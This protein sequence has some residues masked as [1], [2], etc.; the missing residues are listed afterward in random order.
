MNQNDRNRQRREALSEAR[1]QLL[2]RRIQGKRVFSSDSIPV[3]PSRVQARLS[4]AQQRFWYMLQLHPDSPLFHVPG[5]WEVVGELDVDRLEAAFNQVIMRQESLRT[6]FIEVDEEIHPSLAQID[7]YTIEIVD[8]SAQ[9][10]IELKKDKLINEEIRKPFNLA[11]GPLIRLKIIVLEPRRHILIQ[12][13]HHLIS[14]EFSTEI[15]WKE[16]NA[17]YT[18]RAPSLSPLAVQYTDYAHWQRKVFEQGKFNSQMNYWRKKLQGKAPIIQLPFDRPRSHEI[19]YRGGFQR[20]ELPRETFEQLQT[21]YQ[22]NNDYSPFMLFLSVFKALLY[23]YGN[24]EEIWVGTPVANRARPEV[25]SLIGLFLN[26]LVIRTDL[27]DK[28][29]TFRDLLQKVKQTVLQALANQDLPF[30]KLVEELNPVRD[31]S[32]TPL[33][34]VMFIYVNGS[35]EYTGKL[36]GLNFQPIPVE[37]GV[38]KFDLT[39]FLF[40]DSQQISFAIEYKS[41]LFSPETISR[42]FGHFNTILKDILNDPD[43]LLKDYPFLGSEELNKLT[44]DWGK[45]ELYF[46]TGKLLPE[47]ISEVSQECP[48][49]P[50]VI[51]SDKRLSY[52]QLDSRSLQ[53]S[54]YLKN[55]SLVKGSRIGVL[56]ERSPEL[57]AVMLGILRSGCVYIPIDR[58]YPES[59]IVHMIEHS[60]LSLI[61]D[62]GDQPVPEH[63]ASISVIKAKEMLE[64]AGDNS[65]QPTTV[66]GPDDL[67]YIIYTSGSTGSP[68]GVMISHENLLASTL[69]RHRY[70]QKKV[71]CFLL[72][73]SFSFDSSMAGV[74]WTLSLGGK[75]VIPETTESQDVIQL[76]KIIS[77]ENVTHLLALP[78]LYLMMLQESEGQQMNSLQVV[79]VAGEPCFPELVN[80]HY[81]KLNHCELYNE[82]GPTEATVWSHVY[83]V[84][85]ISGR[86]EVP[87]G[88][89]IPSA[90]TRV[91]DADGKLA[92]I[93]IPGELY[94]GGQGI[95]QGYL[96]DDVQTAENFKQ[97]KIEPEVEKRFYASGD[98]VRWDPSGD[99]IFMGRVDNQVKVRGHRVEL[100]EIE[101]HLRE[102]PGIVTA[103]CKI[104]DQHGYGRSDSRIIA[105][106]TTKSK[107][108]SSD[109]RQF[110]NLRMPAYMIPQDWVEVGKM[111]L[112]PNGKI[113]RE[114]LEV[115][116]VVEVSEL[117][118]P[119]NPKEELL[120]QVWTEVLGSSEIGIRENFYDLGGDSISSMQIIAKARKKD[121]LITPQQMQK[122]HT[123]AELAEVAVLG[124]HTVVEEEYTGIFEV[125]PIQQW[126]LQGQ[127]KDPDHWNQYIWLEFKSEVDAAL[128]KSAIKIV[129]DHHAVLKSKF[130]QDQGKW[131]QEIPSSGM[132]LS[133]KKFIRD[134]SQNY[135]DPYCLKSLALEVHRTI[136]IHQGPLVSCGLF[137]GNSPPKL[138]IAIHHLVIDT[139]SWTTVL[140]D[141][142]GAYDH[143]E[144]GTELQLS[145]PTTSFK[146]WV[147]LIKEYSA[148]SAENWVIESRFHQLAE[149]RPHQSGFDEKIFTSDQKISSNPNQN[150]GQMKSAVEVLLLTALAQTFIEV[151]NWDSF[152]VMMEGHGRYSELFDNVDLS[153][154]VGWFTIHYPLRL[155]LTNP[156]DSIVSLREVK[157]TLNN[158]PDNGLTY[159]LYRYIKKQGK[160]VN[161][162]EPDI[163]F[164]YLGNLDINHAE[165]D[166]YR[167]VEP[168]SLSM[169]VQPQFSSLAILAYSV[170]GKLTVKWEFARDNVGQDLRDRMWKFFQNR[171]KELIKLNNYAKDKPAQSFDLIDLDENQLGIISDLLGD[172]D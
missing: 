39:F 11:A 4:F 115:P 146:H 134:K 17:F 167:I 103:V 158:R 89:A 32:I 24:H 143:L 118:A 52:R 88:N 145:Q 73:S 28:S 42:I 169:E 1:K 109:I 125:S 91:L 67:A 124:S 55:Q 90:V 75:F 12:T 13:V 172:E 68:K 154:S 27:R 126:F 5:A 70:Y 60:D 104:A 64:L 45:P 142:H 56:T 41:S 132:A 54:E 168:V 35:A 36:A 21:F 129:I 117:Q 116:E 122:L 51:C 58:E 14:D 119:R 163:W 97:I 38:S 127:W 131:M 112:T 108:D 59:R 23:R 30:E 16:L 22:Q 152:D 156:D 77:E 2:A 8:I 18:S 161:Q 43:Q 95:A 71:S 47:L 66:F 130:I 31:P 100:E 98:L 113:D 53:I 107:L 165:T 141:L 87:I 10:D 33:F 46:Q 139:V 83:S 57:L 150:S 136:D 79:I 62:I 135:Q 15:F 101:S 166:W 50:A 148:G 7:H 49:S 80:L 6:R 48:D 20:Q 26:T 40:E 123:I 78:S 84:D 82:Y 106:Y 29:I 162:M 164:N 140:E 96:N 170:G 102:Y 160:L 44:S 155:I 157:Q 74:F 61:I 99:L 81:E 25:Q 159:G 121:L 114:A 65:H 128:L 69:S 133:F 3:L 94:I 86:H 138:M 92:P 137:L 111:P 93:G 147:G 171:I 144:K 153:N 110:L 151:L 105:Y 120:H 19:D 63:P 9:T 72:L 34:Q 76:L 85:G 149:S 37:P